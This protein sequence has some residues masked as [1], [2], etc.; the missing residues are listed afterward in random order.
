MKRNFEKIVKFSMPYDKRSEIP[1]KNYGI[2]AM[3]IWFILKGK[4]G[5]VQV[6]IG[7]EFYLPKTVHEYLNSNNSYWK[8]LMV[9]SDGG[10][11]K[12][13]T[14][15]DVG[16]HSKKRPDYMETSDKQDC[17]ILGKCYYDGSS[18]RGETDKVAEIF[19]KEGEEGVWKY[20]EKY[21]EEVFAKEVKKE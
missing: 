18:L 3:R 9:D 10:E 17:N 5:A 11:K 19:L 4:E 2:G 16:F 7:T 12:P 15:W 20:L 21:Y 13:F 8:D 1:K 6:L 14:C